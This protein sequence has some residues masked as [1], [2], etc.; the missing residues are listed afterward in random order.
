MIDMQ[1]VDWDKLRVFSKIA[2]VG[3][4]SKASEVLHTSQSAL[5]R[6]VSILEQEVGYALFKRLPRGL[7]LTPEGDVLY[8]TAKD[9]ILRLASA[10]MM[11]LENKEA[12]RGL[13]R[14]EVTHVL[15]TFWLPQ[16]LL[17]FSASYPDIYFKLT[18]TEEPPDFSSKKIDLSLSLFP[19]YDPQFLC[20]PPI[21]SPTGLYA[22][23]LYLKTHGIPKTL[24]DLDQ[25]RLIIMQDLE[26][27]SPFLS[28]WRWLLEIG[29]PQDVPRSF[30]LSFNN[31]Q[32]LYYATRNHA[33]I[34]QLPK[35]CVQPEDNLVE[36]LID[37]PK[38]TVSRYVACPQEVLSLKRVFIFRYFI[39]EKLAA[40][41]GKI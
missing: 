18:F 31:F 34:A 19:T 37:V 30:A 38:P 10:E 17:E 32:G 39:L 35:F 22:S 20:S 36:V 14:V 25:H 12:P 11:L 6:Q 13:I 7:V 3:S 8:K 4:F 26:I 15:G 2:E 23:E 9:I 24:A 5:S 33:G 27:V 21:Q 41:F 16:R 28:H 29:R 1:Q 40:Y